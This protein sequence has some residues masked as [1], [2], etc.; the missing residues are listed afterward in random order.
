MVNKREKVYVT[1]SISDKRLSSFF[2]PF[3]ITLFFFSPYLFRLILLYLNGTCNFFLP[4]YLDEF[5]FL[6]WTFLRGNFFRWGGGGVHVA[7]S[8][9]PAYAPA[10]LLTYSLASWV[11]H[12]L[13][14]LLFFSVF[15]DQMAI[16]F[17]LVKSHL[18]KYKSKHKP[19]P[20]TTNHF[21]TYFFRAAYYC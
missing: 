16:Y 13:T 14:H 11:T 1:I 12:S 7:P 2:Y 15:M 5:F 6:I 17:L 4:A 21:K 3:P 18:I 9:P 20:Q 19:Q 8:A 10:Y